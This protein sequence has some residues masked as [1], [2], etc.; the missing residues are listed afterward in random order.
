MLALDVLLSNLPSL[1]YVKVLFL[2]VSLKQNVS[3]SLWLSRPPGNGWA[4]VDHLVSP[5]GG[6]L[7]EN[8]F[9][10]GG[11]GVYNV[12]SSRSSQHHS[13]FNISLI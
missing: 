13:I 4:F 7:S 9:L 2:A 12:N 10:G 8:H 3:N 5:G 1:N 11:G 6:E